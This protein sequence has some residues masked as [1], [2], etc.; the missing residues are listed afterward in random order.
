M[1]EK[2]ES[3]DVPE[4]EEYS[5]RDKEEEE[6]D[7]EIRTMETSMEVTRTGNM[8]FFVMQDTTVIIYLRVPIKKFLNLI[9]P[10][11]AL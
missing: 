5:E 9:E 1:G 4:I 6:E 10:K 11:L 2:R 3:S 7:L 8:K